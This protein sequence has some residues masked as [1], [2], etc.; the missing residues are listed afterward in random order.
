MS[1]DVSYDSIAF[2]A[3]QSLSGA[4]D[5]ASF[6]RVCFFL[7]L[8][9]KHFA[10]E[11]KNNRSRDCLVASGRFKPLGNCKRGFRNNLLRAEKNENGEYGILKL[12]I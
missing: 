6:V 12:G 10:T 5:R 9:V 3:Q 7:R 4:L 2:I 1:Q 11:V 8:F